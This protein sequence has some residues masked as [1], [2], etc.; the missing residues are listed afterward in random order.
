M[1]DQARLQA[2][3]E[4][5]LEDLVSELVP[6][7]AQRHPQEDRGERQEQER[8][9]DPG[10]DRGHHGEQN[11]AHFLGSPKPARLSSSRP[12]LESTLFMNERASTRR[13]V[14]LTIAI[15]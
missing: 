7:V 15:W 6:E 2:H 4:R 10:R 11:A 12:R 5:V 13:A 14:E 9:G 8:E 3:D 1:G